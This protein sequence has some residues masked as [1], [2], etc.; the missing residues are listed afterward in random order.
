M[1]TL[2]AEHRKLVFLFCICSCLASC[3]SLPTS[4]DRVDTF[5]ISNPENTRAGRLF[6]DGVRTHPGR[7]GLHLLED[8]N[9]AFLVRNAMGGIAEKTIDVQYYIWEGDRSGMLLFHRLLEAAKRG[10]RVRVLIDD[11]TQNA[12]DFDLA[13]F[14]KLPNVE[15]RLFNPFSHRNTKP[16]GFI[17][18]IS[19]VNH[20][21]H[22]KLFVMDNTLAVVGGRNIADA[23]FGFS[24]EY[25]FRDLDLLAA[26]DVVKD[27]SSSFD[28]YWNSP[29]AY[30][31]ADIYRK[32]QSAT[33]I[34]TLTRELSAAVE[35]MGDSFPFSADIDAD[36]MYAQLEAFLPQFDWVNVEVLFDSPGKV[37]G[38]GIALREKILAQLGGINT[39]VS[40]ELAYFVPGK[41]GLKRI[42]AL[43]DSG[44]KIRVLT[45]SMASNDVLAAHSG[46]ASYRKRLLAAGVDLYEYKPD[47]DQRRSYT[48]PRGSAES[49]LHTKAFVIDR[50]LTFIGSFNFD[51]RSIHLNTEVGL[52][53][54][55][56]AFSEKVLRLMAIGRSGANSY[57]L[58]YHGKNHHIIWVELLGTKTK[59]YQHD[60]KTSWWQRVKVNLLRILPIEQHL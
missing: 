13:A 37:V 56:R 47:A 25:N 1:S 17:T 35:N 21:M 49:R 40:A 11:F 43:T 31:A 10:V 30:R 18:D 36:A 3:S 8:G 28:Q 6:Q 48:G 38:D 16:L 4:S 59:T 14:D 26:G 60:P 19:R 23:Y 44:I 41:S 34:D 5:S 52:L 51:P 2:H 29:W 55:N 46:Y 24:N 22:N 9:T 39:E 58:D 15:I 54:D 20:R 50:K 57:K 45:N 27:I 12:N 42:K 33:D 7:S 53:I 32:D